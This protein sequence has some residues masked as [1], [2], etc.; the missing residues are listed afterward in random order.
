MAPK[1][2]TSPLPLPPLVHHSVFTHLF[3]STT[4]SPDDVGGYPSAATAF[5]DAASGTSMTRG[6][7]K[8]WALSLA[9]GLKSHSTTARHAK[10]G[11]TVLIYSH[12]SLAW[13]VLV[14]GSGKHP[15]RGLGQTFIL[16]PLTTF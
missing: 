5:I 13:P 7:L 9:Y 1:I 4:G 11:D 6:Q 10:R 8:H 3:A 14:F 15:Y 16:E 12:N 2:Y